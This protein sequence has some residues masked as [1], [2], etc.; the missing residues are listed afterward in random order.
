MVVLLI[1]ATPYCLTAQVSLHLAAGARYTSTLV[2]DSIVTPIDVRP[3]LAP[4]LAV[5][6]AK[7]IR[8]DWSAEA[9][10]DFSWGALERHDQGAGTVDLGSLS[11][12]ALEVGFRRRLPAGFSARF[13]VGGL[14]YF[15]S[16][17]TGIFRAG[18]GGVFA[19]GGAALAYAPAGALAAR[20]GFGVEAR[21]DVHQ[22]I[23][24]ALRDQGFTTSRTVHR[25]ALAVHAG[26][27][28]PRATAGRTAP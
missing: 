21:Y 3:A 2:H 16:N 27:K 11:T 15:S 25:V 20:W 14:K 17:E 18:S 22:F 26:W 12:L 4:A 7:P 5:T 24:P 23:T 19:L 6:A 28:G 13:A 9:T 8:H 10:L 1:A